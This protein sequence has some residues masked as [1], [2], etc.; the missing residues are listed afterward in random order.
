MP[1][2]RRGSDREATGWRQKSGAASIYWFETDNTLRQ[3]MSEEESLWLNLPFSLCLQVVEK[4]FLQGARGIALVPRWERQDWYMALGQATIDWLD[5]MCD[6][7]VLQDDS[8]TVYPQRD[9]GTR[10]VL[11]DACF[12]AHDDL[13]HVFEKPSQ[14]I[15][16]EGKSSV[17]PGS[18]VSEGE[19]ANTEDSPGLCRRRRRILPRLSPSEDFQ[20]MWTTGVLAHHFRGRQIRSVVGSEA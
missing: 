19:T 9:R 8:G 6:M 15:T 2:K 7:P 16:S 1:K 4:I 11:F 20:C 10:V 12:A 17:P 18:D 5:L 13:H 3:D 14:T